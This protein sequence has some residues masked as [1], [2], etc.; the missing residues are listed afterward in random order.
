M[1]KRK[2][3]VM[4]VLFVAALLTLARGM[5]TSFAQD[6]ASV[7]KPQDNLSIGENDARHLMLLIGPN[8]DGKIT[9]QAWM[10]FMAAEFDRLDKDKSG[11]LDLKELTESRLHVSQFSSVGK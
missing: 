2:N 1:S 5:K 11:T 9:K 7:P 10:R 4:C 8:K 6:T 3:V